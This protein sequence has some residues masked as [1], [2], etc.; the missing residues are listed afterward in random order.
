MDFKNLDIEKLKQRIQ[1]RNKEKFLK[2]VHQLILKA[3]SDLRENSINI[4]NAQVLFSILETMKIPVEDVEDFIKCLME[5]ESP[6][7]EHWFL[8]IRHN[9]LLKEL[10]KDQKL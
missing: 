3:I 10:T 6:S 8:D 2:P 7:P 9:N 4:A 1:E 5:W